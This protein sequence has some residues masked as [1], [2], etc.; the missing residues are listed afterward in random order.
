MF[1]L[2]VSFIFLN[3]SIIYFSCFSL[4]FIRLMFSYSQIFPCSRFS[5]PFKFSF[6]HSFQVSAVYL[7]GPEL[8]C[9]LFMTFSSRTLPFFF[10][11]QFS[12]FL[13]SF[14]LYF[15]CSLINLLFSQSFILPIMSPP[16]SFYSPS[17]FPVFILMFSPVSL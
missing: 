9:F 15:L 14:V 2:S 8:F 4:S 17:I 13:L 1:S 11:F 10:L 16:P 7:S 3:L 6:S 12:S 5:T